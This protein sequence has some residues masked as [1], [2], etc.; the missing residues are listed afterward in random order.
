MLED[1]NNSKVEL[2]SKVLIWL[3]EWKSIQK[4][5]C[6]LELFRTKATRLVMFL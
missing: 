3:A 2:E 5:I 4:D 1:W 6:L